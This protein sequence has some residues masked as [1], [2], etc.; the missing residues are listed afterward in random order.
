MTGESADSPASTLREAYCP[1][2][3]WKSSSPAVMRS[4]SP[5]WSRSAKNITSA[6]VPYSMGKRVSASVSSSGFTVISGS[7]SDAVSGAGTSDRYSML[8]G[9]ADSRARLLP[10]AGD[11]VLPHPQR[12]TVTAS[13]V[14]IGDHIISFHPFSARFIFILK[15]Y[16]KCGQRTLNFPLQNS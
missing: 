3:A 13:I 15:V 1:P 5:S 2:D 11:T 10:A 7:D 12:R 6:S 4:G 9:R 14:T 8:S 16:Y